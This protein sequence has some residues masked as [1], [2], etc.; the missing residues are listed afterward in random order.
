[1]RVIFEEYGSTIL[2]IIGG[3]V[4]LALLV[5]ILS[6]EGNLHELIVMLADSAC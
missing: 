1:M 6:P 5:D 4:V 3:A 2:Q